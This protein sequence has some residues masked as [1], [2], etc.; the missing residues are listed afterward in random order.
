M[1]I[2]P[3][4]WYCCPLF[5]TFEYIFF[6]KLFIKYAEATILSKLWQVLSEF[7]RHFKLLYPRI[8]K[9]LSVFQFFPYHKGKIGYRFK[10]FAVLQHTKFVQFKIRKSLKCQPLIYLL[11]HLKFN[12]LSREINN[13]MER[14]LTNRL[15]IAQSEW[16][17][18]NYSWTLICHHR[19]ST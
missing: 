12:T 3:C 7:S 2:E 6:D 18:F 15:K 10:N 9:N 11:H 13:I 1:P 16:E 17:T 5:T 19:P 14:N 4:E 8:C